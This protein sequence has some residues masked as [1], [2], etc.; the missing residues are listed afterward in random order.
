MTKTLLRLALILLIGFGSSLQAAETTIA[1]KP[2]EHQAPAF[3]LTGV[4]GKAHS[5]SDFKGKTVV[6]EW[7]N[8]DCP[9]VK[10][11]YN[12]TSA[13]PALQKRYREQ[14]VVW[15]SICSSAPGKQGNLDTKSLKKRLKVVKWAGDAY[16]LDQDGK[17]GKAYGAKTTPHMF[18]VNAK[19][20][21]VYDGAIDSIPGTTAANIQKATPYLPAVLDPLLAGEA[22]SFRANKPYGCSVKY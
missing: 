1:A 2:A 8:F 7:I 22:V 18:V 9:F 16:L 11:H 21:L 13:M 12:N 14:G 17:V 10:N 3:T 6:L 19:G 20:Q 5:L 4:D 15:L